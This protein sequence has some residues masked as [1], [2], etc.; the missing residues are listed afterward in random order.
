MRR[1]E[2]RRGEEV[3]RNLQ[4]VPTIL[5]MIEALN[6]SKM[7]Q[8]SSVSALYQSEKVGYKPAT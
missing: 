1:G 4:S 3:Y 8:W 6:L 7:Q 5:A 2:E